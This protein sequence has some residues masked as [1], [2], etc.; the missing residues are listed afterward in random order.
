MFQVFYNFMSAWAITPSPVFELSAKTPN[1]DHF[2]L[3]K[4]YVEL[5]SLLLGVNH[6]PIFVS[7]YVNVPVIRNFLIEHHNNSIRQATDE[8]YI[9]W[10]AE[11]H[12]LISGLIRILD[13]SPHCRIS[14]RFL[15]EQTAHEN[16]TLLLLTN[17]AFANTEEWLLSLCLLRCALILPSIMAAAQ[18]W[19]H[20]AIMGLF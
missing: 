3:I 9:K 13:A 10:L 8:N 7:E 17:P 14:A 20:H 15:L 12:S 16:T 2:Y 1:L 6:T 18:P 4:S 5:E 19:L 11:G